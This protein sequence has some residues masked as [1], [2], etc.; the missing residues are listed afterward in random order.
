MA[1]DDPEIVGLIWLDL[2]VNFLCYERVQGSWLTRNTAEAAFFIP[3]N[4]WN[5]HHQCLWYFMGV[6]QVPDGAEQWI[7]KPLMLPIQQIDH[8]LL[9]LSRLILIKLRLLYI[10]GTFLLKCLRAKADGICFLCVCMQ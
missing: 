3:I 4:K 8:W 10:N 1:D 6:L 9:Y 7:D 5:D 2:F